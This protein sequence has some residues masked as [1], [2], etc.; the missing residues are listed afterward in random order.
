MWIITCV[1]DCM[2]MYVTPICR[3]TEVIARELAAVI[4]KKD[5]HTCIC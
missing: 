4:H 1:C 3:N 5:N 2:P